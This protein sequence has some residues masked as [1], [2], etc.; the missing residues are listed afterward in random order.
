MRTRSRMRI[1]ATIF[2]GLSAT[3]LGLS[4]T[5]AGGDFLGGA[6]KPLAAILFIVFFIL[7]LLKDEVEQYNDDRRR[8]LSTSATVSSATEPVPDKKSQQ[9]DCRANRLGPTQR[10]GKRHPRRRR[11]HDGLEQEVQ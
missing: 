9:H 5:K 11:R 6:L 7:Q 4:F 10:L 2:L 3:S 8:S 1:F